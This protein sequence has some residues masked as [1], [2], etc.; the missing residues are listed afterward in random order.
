MYSHQA[1]VQAQVRGN[2]LPV[3]CSIV[4][5]QAVRFSVDYC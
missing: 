3:A 4:G 2:L 5:E 1:K